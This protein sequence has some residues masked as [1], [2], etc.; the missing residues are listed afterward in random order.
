MKLLESW[1]ETEGRVNTTQ[2][3]LSW[4]KRRNTETAVSIKKISPERD[5][6]WRY[7]ESEG[8]FANESRSFFTVKGLVCGETQQPVYIQSEIGYLGILCKEIDGILHFLMQAKIEP[9]NVNKIQISPTIQATKS[10]FT[11][12][13]GGACPAY[14]DYFLHAER[15]EIV[16][17]QIQSEQS[18]RFV[19]KR[20]RNIIVVVDPNEP[21]EAL[22]SHRW[23][24]LGQIKQ[25]LH[26][27]NLVNMD[28]RTV[29]SCIP[30]H[31][32]DY[33]QAKLLFNDKALGRSI[34]VGDGEN[35]LPQLY[36]EIN[37]IRMFDQQPA[38][39]VPLHSMQKW[40]WENG[41]FVCK[42][43]YHF[44]MIFCDIAI[45][46]REVKRWTQPLFEATGTAVFGLICCETAGVLR[47][48]VKVRKEFGS[49]DGAELGPTLQMEADEQPSDEIER[50]FLT[51]YEA[52]QGVICDIMLSEE[53]GR[54]YHEQNR[55]VILRLPPER[56]P[57]LPHGYFLV[58]YKTLCTL[59]QVNNTLNIQ[60]RNLLSLLE[61]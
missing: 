2:E 59:V 12:K 43:G 61:A 37:N 24:T 53:G 47:F 22:P 15:Y 20:N 4:V 10:N 41:E 25:L 49:F 16:V 56:L 48:L 9:G 58:D 60:L 14:L 50:F 42:D 26:Y 44:K 55:N 45:E 23:M 29:I 57:P 11:Q 27:D 3:L 54:F 32:L 35:H 28:T 7:F 6:H 18:S 30:F 36:R 13:H 33:T 21:V 31:L 52:K 40:H 19:G 51:C 39:L 8:I 1:R 5:K 34:C 38:Q 46:G 17:D